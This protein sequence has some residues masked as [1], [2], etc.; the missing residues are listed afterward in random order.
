[1]STMLTKSFFPPKLALDPPIHVAYPNPACKYDP[2][3]KEQIRK[4]LAR[5]K[6]LKAPGPDGIPNIVLTKCA[7]T[8]TDRLYYIYNAMLERNLYYAPWKASTTVVLCKLGKARYDT[9]KSYHPIALLN[10]LC[11]VLTAI[12]A[13]IMTYYTETHLLLPA[14]HFGG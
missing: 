12:V 5:L 4:H 14:H 2:I 9:P 10:T 11:K 1:K 6:P 8:L 3:K 7:D 13:D